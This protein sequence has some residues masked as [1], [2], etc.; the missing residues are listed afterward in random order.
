MP[1]K[2]M[3]TCMNNV[4]YTLLHDIASSYSIQNKKDG[5]YCLPV[6]CAAEQVL[7]SATV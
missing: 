5:V 7:Y 2:V 6:L 3:I 4:L 1:Y